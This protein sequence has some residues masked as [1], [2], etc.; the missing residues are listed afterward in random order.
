MS[1]V[2]NT[3]NDKIVN[4]KFTSLDEAVEFLKPYFEKE[5]KSQKTL[6]ENGLS[7]D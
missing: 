5:D 3:L 6:I 1:L 4:K 2:I 7:E